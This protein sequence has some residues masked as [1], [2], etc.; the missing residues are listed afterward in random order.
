MARLTTRKERLAAHERL[1]ARAERKPQYLYDGRKDEGRSLPCDRLDAAFTQGITEG[2]ITPE[3]L[4]DYF[5]D[6]FALYRSMMPDAQ[7]SYHDTVR[8][9]AEAIEAVS[10][11]RAEPTPENCDRAARE[12]L[13]DVVVST[14]H[15]KTLQRK[16]AA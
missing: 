2:W 11:A 15:A 10:V 8:E 5:G 6:L 3:V 13:E 16:G 9:K 14:A 1:C 7:A 4:A 12:L